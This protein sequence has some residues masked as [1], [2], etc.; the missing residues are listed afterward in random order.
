MLNAAELSAN[1]L[2]AIIPSSVVAVAALLTLLLFLAE[3]FLPG[4]LAIA[5]KTLPTGVRLFSPAVLCVPYL[6]VA[7]SS[8]TFH[9]GWLALYALLPVAIAILMWHAAPLDPRQHR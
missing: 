2:S 6:L 8:G 9:W 3:A 5:T 1:M 4:K 7:A